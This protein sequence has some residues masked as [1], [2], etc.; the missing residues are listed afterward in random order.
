MKYLATVLVAAL[1]AGVFANDASAEPPLVNGAVA[2]K[3]ELRRVPVNPQDLPPPTA[4]RG[5]VKLTFT[6]TP[7]GTVTDVASGGKSVGV[8]QKA[9]ENASIKALRQWTYRPYMVDGKPTAMRVGI[10]FHFQVRQ[11][12]AAYQ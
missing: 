11:W 12:D 7:D 2:A 10:V 8:V 3:L 5:S 6:V 1:A 9:L 4:A